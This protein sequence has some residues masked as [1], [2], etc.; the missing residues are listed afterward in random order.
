[1]DVNLFSCYMEP[2]SSEAHLGSVP[3]SSVRDTKE[4]VP[5]SLG[6]GATPGDVSGKQMRPWPGSGGVLFL[7]APADAGTA[8]A[9]ILGAP[10]Y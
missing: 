2:P 7:R 5:C 6:E 8:L 3:K 9:A 4:R 10:G 1:M